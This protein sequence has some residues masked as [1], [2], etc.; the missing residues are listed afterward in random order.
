MTP[1]PTASRRRVGA[2]TALAAVTAL[3][4]AVVLAACGVPVDSS[5]TAI[6]DSDVPFE[7][8]E[9]APTT[10]ST[11]TTVPDGRPT[12]TTAAPERVHLFLVRNDRIER[13]ERIVALQLGMKDRLGLLAQSPTAA[14]VEAGFR[15]AVPPDFFTDVV[16]RGGV[17]EVA[18]TR[19]LLALPPTE[20]VLAFAQIT[21]TATDLPGIG[22]VRFTVDGVTI[23]ALDDEGLVVDGLVS[24]DTYRDLFASSAGS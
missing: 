12:T 21:Y 14:E 11:T 18:L 22:Q 2:R 20:Q 13:R 5:I 17:A 9:S 7:L 24:K 4:A 19:E 23:Q 16:T 6:S 15:T 10:T 8:L 1:T 3:L